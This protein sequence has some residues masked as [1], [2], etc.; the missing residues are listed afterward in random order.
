MSVSTFEELIKYAI[1]ELIKQGEKGFWDETCKYRGGNGLKCAVGMC[2]AD[3]HYNEDMEGLIA[4]AEAVLLPLHRSHP[5]IDFSS[6]HNV[7]ILCSLQRCHDSCS[8][9]GFVDEF[10]LAIK[11]SVD[12]GNLPKYCLECI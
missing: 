2:V 6:R 3:E 7:D 9:I 10:K 12:N 11:T 8:V 4:S 1:T 5:D